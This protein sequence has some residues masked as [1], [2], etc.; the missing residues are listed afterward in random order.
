[1]F[2][3]QNV[4]KIVDLIHKH[5]HFQSRLFRSDVSDDQIRFARK[6]RNSLNSSYNDRQSFFEW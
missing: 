5:F 4:L 6:N 3:I 1:M 2:Q